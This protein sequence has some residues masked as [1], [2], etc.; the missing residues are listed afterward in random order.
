LGYQEP[1]GEIDVVGLAAFNGSN[2]DGRYLL[3]VYGDVFDVSDRPDKYAAESPYASLCG[4]DITWGLF[5]GIDMPEYC[6]R[7]YDLFKARDAGK[8]KM[9]GVCSWRAW[10]ENEYGKPVGR[11]KEWQQEESLPMPPLEE[12]E[13][14]CVVM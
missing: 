10:Y 1:V 14:T 4:M 12:C 6:N 9:G 3:S 5:V 7:F 13:E 2:K 8:D 11:L